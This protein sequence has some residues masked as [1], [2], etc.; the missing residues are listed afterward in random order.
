MQRRGVPRAPLRPR[1]LRRRTTR[2]PPRGS[3]RRPNQNFGSPASPRT[4]ARA[5]ARRPPWR[6]DLWLCHGICLA[7]RRRLAGGA[8][9][10]VGRYLDEDPGAVVTILFGLHRRGPDGT[11]FRGP[12]CS[13][14]SSRSPSGPPY[15]RSVR[16]RARGQ[17]LVVFTD[18]AG[19]GRP[20]STTCG[21]G[22]GRTYAATT[23]ARLDCRAKPGP[24]GQL[25]SHPQPLPDGAAGLAR[26]RAH[27]QRFSPSLAD[28]RNALRSKARGVP[29]FI[30]VDFYD[31]G[32][33]LAVAR[34]RNEMTP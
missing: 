29:N 28:H 6:D 17:R 13:T 15:L 1:G 27:G 7:G 2:C 21:R 4:G 10:N 8:S 23:P 25:S 16:S 11:A 18:R 32:D 22:P 9:A 19:G 31:I 26:P 20:G 33:V 5:D 14:T 34:A 12:T 24:R 30:T 3:L